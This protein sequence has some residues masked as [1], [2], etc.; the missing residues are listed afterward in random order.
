MNQ[1]GR[2]LAWVYLPSLDELVWEYVMP[3]GV[4]EYN[5]FDRLSSSSP[6]LIPLN[7]TTRQQGTHPSFSNLIATVEGGYA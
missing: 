1:R 7:P 4:M 3:F 2:N 6:N 5:V